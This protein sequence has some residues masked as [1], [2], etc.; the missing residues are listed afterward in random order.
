MRNLYFPTFLVFYFAYLEFVYFGP[1]D[2]PEFFQY[3][4]VPLNRQSKVKTDNQNLFCNY[5]F[6]IEVEA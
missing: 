4:C 3:F 5:S 1:Y 2:V 6:P